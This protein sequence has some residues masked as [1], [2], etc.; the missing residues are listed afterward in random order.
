MSEKE[1]IVSATGI[2]GTATFLS[3]ILGYLRDMVI[4]CFFGADVV[5]DAFF[6][7]FRIP[8]TLRRLFGEGALTVSFVPI[9]SEY[10][11]HKEKQDWEQL[12][13][14]AFT[15]LSMI[16]AGL[17][18]LGVLC[19]PWLIRVLAPGFGDPEQFRLTVVM[20]RIVFPY[21]FFIGLVALSMGVLNA[22][23]HFLAPA[24]A[25][26]FLNVSMI[27]CV[28]LLARRI[29]PP[30]MALAFCGGRVFGF[31]P[32]FGSARAPGS[33]ESVCSWSLPW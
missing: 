15:L 22:L 28:F 18:V 9:F 5:T 30:V 21:L 27:A 16:L 31:V 24:M 2:V 29:S 23:G 25:P 3:R 13:N 12:L 26:V 4:A 32:T 19:A 17:S 7:A 11:H 6:V 14:R 33:A 20:T 8:N 10:L 1:K